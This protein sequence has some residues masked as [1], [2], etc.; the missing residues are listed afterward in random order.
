MT[1]LYFNAALVCHTEGKI[2]DDWPERQK[3]FLSVADSV[4][5]TYG[6]FG[7]TEAGRDT[8]SVRFILGKNLR[9]IFSWLKF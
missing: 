1:I 3:R 5:K 9:C 2:A 7:W 6:T 4:E 8:K